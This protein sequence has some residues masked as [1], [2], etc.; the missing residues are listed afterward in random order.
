MP[1]TIPPTIVYIDRDKISLCSSTHLAPLVF[2]FTP[3]M[4]ADLEITNSDE[5]NIGLRQFIEQNKIK[6]EPI[7]LI[8]S[9][10]VYFEKNYTGVNSPSQEEVD[11]FIQ[12]VPFS[13]TSSKVFKVIS[14]YKQVVLNRDFYEVFKQTFNDLGFTVMAIVPGFALGQAA[15]NSFSEETCRVIYKKLDQII[16]DSIIGASDTKSFQQQEQAILEK[17]KVVITI[18]ILLILIACGAAIYYFVIRRPPPRR[19]VSNIV[20]EVVPIPGPTMSPPSTPSSELLKTLSIQITNS[21][22]INGLGSSLSAQLK[23]YG[24]TNIQ[25]QNSNK[26]IESTLIETSNYASTVAGEYIG[27]FIDIRF[28]VTSVVINSKAKFDLKFELGKNTP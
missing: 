26:I 2:K 8:V 19:L 11:N 28:P 13:A 23:S 14:G 27:N 5:L 22:G 9:K 3:S 1:K 17:N 12:S 24:F 10:F 20:R 6:P 21:S 18:S 15:N 16:A 7:V 4:I 25:L